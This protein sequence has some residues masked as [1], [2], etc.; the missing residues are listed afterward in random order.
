MMAEEIAMA[1]TDSPRSNSALDAALDVFRIRQ[2][3]NV[4]VRARDVAA[5]IRDDAAF[6]GTVRRAMLPLPFDRRPAPGIA[7]AA[8]LAGT[9]RG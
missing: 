1:T 2:Y 4:V 9:I 3:F 6:L 8:G 5:G 7:T